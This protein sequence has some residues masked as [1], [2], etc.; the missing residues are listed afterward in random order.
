MPGVRGG[1]GVFDVVGG[2]S[3]IPGEGSMMRRTSLIISLYEYIRS[4]SLLSDA[5]AYNVCCRLGILC[6]ASGNS[7]D[8]LSTSGTCRESQTSM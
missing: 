8:K 5:I 7:T 6:P 4:L 3:M 1:C 2:R